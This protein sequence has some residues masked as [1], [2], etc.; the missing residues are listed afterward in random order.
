M[1]LG[2]L[3]QMWSG[4]NVYLPYYDDAEFRLRLVYP[5]VLTVTNHRPCKLDQS[6]RPSESVLANEKQGR[7]GFAF[8]IVGAES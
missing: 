2:I 8:S 3:G 4:K 1:I 7:A 6:N 5:N